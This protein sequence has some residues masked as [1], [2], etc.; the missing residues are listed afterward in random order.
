MTDQPITPITRYDYLIIGGGIIGLATAW[1]LQQRH[2]A[3][4][5]LLLEKESGYAQHQT[6]HNSGVI[7]AGV[8]YAPG[9]LKANFCK[10]GVAATIDFCQQHGIAYE[11]C[12]KLLVA[13]NAAELTRMQALYQRALQNGLRLE[14]LDATQL[15]VKEPNISGLGAIL[16]HDTA[17]VDYRQVSQKIAE[18]YR[19]NGGESRLQHEVIALTESAENIEVKAVHQGSTHTFQTRYLVSCAGLMA[20]RIAQMLT[21]A[22]DFRIIPFRGE[23]YRLPKKYN[24]LVR[25][26]I[27]PIP[28]PTLPFLGVH[29]TRMIDGSITVGPNAVQGWKRE[30]Y[31]RLNF[32]PRDVGE[33]LAF[34]GFWKVLTKHLRPGLHEMFNSVWKP[35]YLRQVQK[36]CPQITLAD[37]QPYPAGVRAQAVSSRGELIHD[38]LF[39]SSQRSLHVCNAPSPAATSA[40]PIAQHI[41]NKLTTLT[42]EH[43]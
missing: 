38:F 15:K 8:Y 20:D 43:A 24:A 12:G 30:G 42:G 6:G 11:Q 25:H 16:V 21:I 31:G 33:M 28:D 13:T 1:Q 23:Y 41:C 9:S 5:I 2:P 35:G 22:T 32:S 4:R 27:Y 14:L 29:L 26:L 40:L 39:A 37:L 34:P 7:H 18:C 19:A 36:Y 17:I 3:A 10:A